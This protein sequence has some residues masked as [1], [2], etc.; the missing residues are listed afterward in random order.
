MHLLLPTQPSPTCQSPS[1]HPPLSIHPPINVSA[2]NNAFVPTNMAIS[3]NTITTDASA[4]A[5][6]AA[7]ITAAASIN[8]SHTSPEIHHFQAPTHTHTL[9]THTE[10][11]EIQSWLLLGLGTT[12]KVWCMCAWL[13]SHLKGLKSNFKAY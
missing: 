12:D 1:M 8:T 2:P 7:T 3:T 5:N 6:P 11:S 4:P 10:G 9:G 13:A